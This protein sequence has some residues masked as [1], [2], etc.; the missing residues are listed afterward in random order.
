MKKLF[1][2]FLIFFLSPIILSII[3]LRPI[4]LIRFGN[5]SIDRIGRVFDLEAYCNEKKENSFDVWYAG[6]NVSNY[7]LLKIYRRNLFVLRNIDFILK[8][9]EALS[10]YFKFLNIH[11]IENSKILRNKKEIYFKKKTK[12]DLTKQELIS[13]NQILKR[14]NIPLNAKIICFTARDQK[15]L[16][17]TQ[18]YK[19]FSYH[20]FRNSKIDNFNKF[21]KIYLKKG[22]YIFR[23]GKIANKKINFKHP[24]LIDYPYHQMKSDFM[25]FFLAKKC[26]LWIGSNSGVDMLAFLFKKPLLIL[27]MSPIGFAPFNREKTLISFKK[28]FYKKSKKKLKLKN[29]FEKKIFFTTNGQSYNKKKIKLRELN[30]REILNNVNF[31]LN[32]INNNWKL[33]KKERDYQF[34]I[35]K[36]LKKYFY[37]YNNKDLNISKKFIIYN[38]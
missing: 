15:Y 29:I 11:L 22:F 6:K 34:K 3:L 5:L 24:N 2:F 36:E 23:M 32:L 38:L 20:S 14:F 13:G 4:I 8:I 33:N 37:L 12:L 27:N 28:F 9:F 26:Y 21:L 10:K 19:S 30:Q 16:K 31:L 35:K 1:L 7:F 17:V 18:K 25:D